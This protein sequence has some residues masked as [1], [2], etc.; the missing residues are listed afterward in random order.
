MNYMDKLI[1]HAESL[2]T[3]RASIEEGTRELE[4][5]R[6]VD[7]QILNELRGLRK[8]LRDAR[9]LRGNR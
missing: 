1:E 2:R 7:E 6:P 3:I 8:D 9:S 5:L 4:K